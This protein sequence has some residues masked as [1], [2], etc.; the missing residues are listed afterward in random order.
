M[1]ARNPDLIEIPDTTA[2]VSDHPCPSCGPSCRSP[3]NRQ[4]KTL[5][6]WNDGQGFISWRCARCD[7]TGWKKG[8]QR[9]LTAP[10]RQQPQQPPQS[11][12]SLARALWAR[13][14]PI[15][16]TPAETYLRSRQCFLDTP[17]IRF[18]HGDKHPPTM[19]GKFQSG[20]VH[21]TRLNADGLGKAGTANDKLMFG[22]VSGSPLVIRESSGSSGRI[23]RTGLIICEGIEDGLSIALATKP[24]P[25]IGVWVSG[26]ASMLPKLL[27]LAKQVPVVYLAF[28]LDTAG[29]NAYRK[30]LEL[31][32]DIR[33]IRFPKQ[34]DANT[35][36]RQPDG[37][38]RLRDMILRRP[39]FHR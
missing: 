20:A 39:T 2:P 31:R 30:A 23:F 27:P 3:L 9:D 36:I 21:L 38:A 16:G 37:V 32:P 13:S 6:V 11:R 10:S 5:R 19:I 17:N 28:D 33:S 34:L 24:W 25:D 4:R 14:V 22:P 7:T 12:E 26:S 29:I 18:L 8:T 1:L 35:I 15:L